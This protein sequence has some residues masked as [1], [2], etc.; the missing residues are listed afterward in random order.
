MNSKPV[1]KSR[2]PPNTWY[3]THE[4][5]VSWLRIGTGGGLMWTRWWT[6]GFNKM[7]GSSRVAAQLA[8]SQEGLSSMSEWYSIALKV[9]NFVIRQL[10]SMKFTVEVSSHSS[11]RN[12]LF[13]VACFWTERGSFDEHTWRTFRQAFSRGFV[14]LTWKGTGSSYFSS[15]AVKHAR[16]IHWVALKLLYFVK[17][18]SLI[19]FWLHV[20][21]M[22]VTLTAFCTCSRVNRSAYNLTEV[23]FSHLQP[24]Y[25]FSRLFQ[26]PQKE[27]SS[28]RI[29][30]RIMK[31]TEWGTK[32]S[33]GLMDF[34][35]AT[36]R[37]TR[38]MHIS[39]SLR[40]RHSSSG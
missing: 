39:C 21:M 29:S 31:L 17:I 32:M 8:A 36:W 28:T 11:L 40:P 35:P 1:Y 23:H 30:T 24:F 22:V 2:T 20:S 26:L 7:L 4:Y 12:I 34:S 14:A 9:H 19:S 18:F 33:D 6:S 5:I 15:F 10:H 25:C 37:N 38:N 27:R 13:R 3:Y 16:A